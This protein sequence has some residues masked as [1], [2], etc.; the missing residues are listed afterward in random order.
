MPPRRYIRI[1]LRGL[2][3]VGNYLDGTYGSLGGW[4][5]GSP[6]PGGDD[7]HVVYPMDLRSICTRSQ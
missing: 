5:R 7:L 3:R 1:N 6:G 4:W 2:R